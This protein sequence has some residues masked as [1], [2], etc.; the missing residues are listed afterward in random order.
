MLIRPR[1][2]HYIAY[3]RMKTGKWVQCNDAFVDAM[4][5]PSYVLRDC[6][7]DGYLYLY[8]KR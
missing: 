2:G 6:A 8:A 4:D 3:L 5:D 7:D 1:L